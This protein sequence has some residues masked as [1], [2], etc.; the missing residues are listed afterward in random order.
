MGLAR[1]IPM[2]PA[3]V[4]TTVNAPHRKKLTAEEIA[5]CLKD[6]KAA[7]TI[8][9]HMSSFFG[10]VKPRLQCEFAALF[11]ISHAQL[12][13]AA[14]AFAKYSGASYPLAA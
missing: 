10:D 13:E 11:N 3:L 9:G 2:N 6:P 5:R 1:V 14:K 7:K 8:P 12:V 4:M